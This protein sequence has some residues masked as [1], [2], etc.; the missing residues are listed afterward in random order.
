VSSTTPRSSWLALVVVALVLASGDASARPFGG[1]TRLRAKVTRLWQRLVGAP[2]PPQIPTPLGRTI[3]R[4]V[5][6]RVERAQ[7]IISR[8]H[9]GDRDVVKRVVTEAWKEAR[10]RP[11]G[12]IRGGGARSVGLPTTTAP[13]GDPTRREIWRHV[14]ALAAHASTSSAAMRRLALPLIERIVGLAEA[15]AVADATPD[16]L[17]LALA[18]EAEVWF[19]PEERGVRI[20]VRDHGGGRFRETVIR[21]LGPGGVLRIA[22]DD[23]ELIEVHGVDQA[24]LTRTTTTFTPRRSGAAQRR[25]DAAFASTGEAP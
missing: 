22:A 13:S 20:T 21:L 7:E 14:T 3:G 6:Y 19:R 23:R 11:R 18:G 25:L 1:A 5:D 16:G 12:R 8:G 2:A 4:R 10:L 15:G 9:P 24:Y 17:R